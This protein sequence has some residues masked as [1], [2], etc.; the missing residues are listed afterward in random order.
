[1]TINTSQLL[2]IFEGYTEFLPQTDDGIDA[3]HN[4]Q[5]LIDQVHTASFAEVQE[6]IDN[7]RV[8]FSKFNIY[9]FND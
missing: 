3:K 6:L 4:I 8:I 9:I 5:A 2:D 1:M 7:I